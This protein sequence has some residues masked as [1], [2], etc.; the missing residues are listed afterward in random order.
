MKNLRPTLRARRTLPPEAALFHGE[1]IRKKPQA[2]RQ[3]ICGRPHCATSQRIKS[4]SFAHTSFF[5]SEFKSIPPNNVDLQAILCYK[6][7]KSNPFAIPRWKPPLGEQMMEENLILAFGLTALAG[8]STGIGSALAFF[9]KRTNKAFLSLALG[10]SAGVM[11]YVSFVEIFTKAQYAL[12]E[13]HG[14]IVGA[15]MT[16]GAFFAGVLF[17]AVIDRLIP[18]HENP[19]EARTIE[20]IQK[21]APPEARLMRMGLLTAL[22][23]GIHNFPEGLATF[24][25]TL[26]DPGIGIAIAVAVAIHNIPEGIAIS[27]PVYFATGS[28][29]KAFW[30]SFLSGVS[31]PAVALAGYA[32][33]RPFFTNSIF[34]LLFASVA[35]IMV[36]ISLD[37]LLPTAREYGTGHLAIYGFIAGMAVMAISLL[38]F[39]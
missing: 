15:W 11:I 35:G 9:T 25:A 14:K 27:V 16:V 8:L 1:V 23:I 28:K 6:V 19:H 33:L 29:K 22:A 10:F 36:F 32:I 37:E 18:S 34:G 13:V 5:A 21:P 38:L 26:T 12:A 4:S 20:E 30:F 31:E 2:L 24:F 17:I 3:H 7:A 39:I